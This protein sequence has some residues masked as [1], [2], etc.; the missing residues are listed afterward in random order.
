MYKFYAHPFVRVVCGLPTSWEPIV[1]TLYTPSCVN[2]ATWSLCNR[3]LAIAKDKAVE[4]HDAE[5]LS[6]L[7]YL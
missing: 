5:T 4:I 1:A 6:L 3:F 2:V 7:Q